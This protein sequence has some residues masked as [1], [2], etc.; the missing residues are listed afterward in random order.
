V[1]AASLE[2]A[3]AYPHVGGYLLYL[4]IE[5]HRLRHVSCDF[6]DGRAVRVFRCAHVLLRYL[7]LKL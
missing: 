3:D 4:C 1:A 6:L 2:L 7:G 5:G